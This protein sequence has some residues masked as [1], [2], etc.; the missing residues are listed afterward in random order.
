MNADGPTLLKATFP[1][2]STLLETLG[3]DF[4]RTPFGAL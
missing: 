3:P 2:V 1:K 4:D